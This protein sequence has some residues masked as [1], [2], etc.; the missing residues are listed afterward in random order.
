[1]GKAGLKCESCGNNTVEETPHDFYCLSCGKHFKKE[2][3]V[4]H[5]EAFP[6]Y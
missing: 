5:H 2:E 6:M 1:M 4:V 3:R